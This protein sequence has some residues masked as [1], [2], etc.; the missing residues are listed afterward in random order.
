[1]YKYTVT[2]YGEIFYILYYF[3]IVGIISAKSPVDTEYLI[4]GTEVKMFDER[5]GVFHSYNHGVTVIVPPGAIPSG[6]LAELK[7]AATLVAPVKFTSVTPVSAMFWLCMEVI[8]QKPIQIRLPQM[9][10]KNRN[11]GLQ[12][13]KSLHSPVKVIEQQM[14]V[15]DGGKFTAGQ[16][17][18]SIEVDHFCYYCIVDDKLDSSNVPQ[19]QYLLVAM[20]Q[21]HL[22]TKDINW[23]VHICVVPLIR[24]CVKVRI[25]VWHTYGIRKWHTLHTYMAYVWHMYGVQ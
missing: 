6:I 23:T 1:M 8:L 5:G 20:K 17:Y 22:S 7:F 25:Y 13:A 21:H 2:Y 15:L 4:G 24:T 19:N 3:I 9:F 14:D 11:N 16:C 10:T 12:F 18:A